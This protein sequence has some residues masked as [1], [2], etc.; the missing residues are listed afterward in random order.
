V[1]FVPPQE[2]LLIGLLVSIQAVVSTYDGWYAPI[3]FSEEDK[4]PSVNVPRSTLGGAIACT[5]IFLLVNV[6]LLH[7]MPL[8]QLQASQVPVADTAKA[9]LGGYGRI[10][11]L[12][13][14]LATT[15]SCANATILCTPRIL[16]AMA[17]DRL[18]PESVTTVN[19]GGTPSYALLFCALPC[20]VLIL[21]GSFESLIA[22]VSVL[23]VSVYA[24][25]FA[26]LL[27]LRRKEPNLRRPYRAWWYPWSTIAVLLASVAFLLS[28]I[29]GDLK[30]SLFTL[31]LIALTFPAYQAIKQRRVRH[32]GRV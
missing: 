20:S 12:A 31:I 9:I 13:L 7:V 4:N 1:G 26:S 25:G 27:A 5:V 6:A 29:L 22:T 16:F 11:I 19:R 3:Y 10:F 18:L 21:S 8:R 2:T 32:L 24:S 14:S 17:R 23:Y 15:I 30:H 28:A